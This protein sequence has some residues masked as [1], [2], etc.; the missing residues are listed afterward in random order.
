MSSGQAGAA[1]DTMSMQQLLVYLTQQQQSYQA[2]M[3]TQLQAQMQQANARFEYLVASRGEQR[4]KDPPMYEGKYGEDI[5]LWIFAT[6]QYYASRRELMEA[7]TSDFVTMISSNLGKSVLNWYR[8]FIAE[9][10]GTNV[11]PTWSLFKGR[12][13]TRFRPKDFGKTPKSS[14]EGFARI[15]KLGASCV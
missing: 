15:I 7:D 9:C 8:A 4:K 11:Q 1:S 14:C 6:E 13:R 12:L 10:E 5:E 3:Q 2:Q